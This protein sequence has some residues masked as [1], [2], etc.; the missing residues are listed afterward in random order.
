MLRSKA[1]IIRRYERIKN[2]SGC[3]LGWKKTWNDKN[4]FVK[5]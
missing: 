2:C 3:G 4:G 5:D 1:Q